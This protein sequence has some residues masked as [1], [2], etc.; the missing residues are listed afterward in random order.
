[1]HF[2][3]GNDRAVIVSARACASKVCGMYVQ[4][5]CTIKMGFPKQVCGQNSRATRI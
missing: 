1:M 5:I 2:A 3:H 4:Y